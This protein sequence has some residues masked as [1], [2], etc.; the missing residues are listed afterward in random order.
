[1]TAHLSQ[2][3]ARVFDAVFYAAAY[4]D[5][6]AA[7]IA[8][9]EHYFQ[10]GIHENRDPNPYFDA[11]WYARRNPAAAAVQGG[12]IVHYL[13]AG[14]AQNRHPHPRF[15][16]VWY[17][18]QHPEAAGNQLHYH[19]R[20]G[21]QRGWPTEPFDI[22][23]LVPAPS[24]DGRRRP[25]ILFVA[26]SLG[27]G[28]RR[29]L[30]AL[31][32]DLR[33]RANCLILEGTMRGVA[34]SVPAMPDYPAVELADDRLPELAPLLADFG[35]SRVHIHHAMEAG[36]A[37][38]RLIHAL[39]VPFDV[40]VHDYHAI[41]PQI[42][43][44][45]W[46]DAQYCGEPGPA[47]CNACIA[48]RPSLE[49][50]DILTWRAAHRWM[51]LEADRVFCPS[52]DV[53][54]RLARH[55][56]ARRAILV[57]HEAVASGP[58]PMS[59]PKLSPRGRLRVAVLGVLAAHKGLPA[60]L[61]VLDADGPIDLQLIGHTEAPLSVAYDGR[62]HVTGFYAEADLP[63]L[64]R[65][66]KPHVVWFPAQWPET[67]S[68]TLSAAI[69]AG[70]PIVASRIG[71]FPERLAGRPLTWLIDP[72]APAGGWLAAFAEVRAT[73]L[74]PLPLPATEN[75]LEVENFYP[76]GYL[77]PLAS[78]PPA[79]RGS[80]PVDLRR[81]GRLSVIVVPECFGNG[82]ATPCAFIRLLQPLDHPAIGAEIDVILADPAEALGL[83]A[84]IVATQR[85]ALADTASADALAAHCRAHG[86]ALLY[87][88]DDDLLHIPLD[89]PEAALLRPRASTVARMLHHA[90]AV[91]VS[92][93]GLKIAIAAVRRD[94][95]VVANG[96]DERLWFDPPPPQPGPVRIL[97]MGSATHD[98][99]FD[100]V[101]PALAQLQETFND[102]LRIDLLGFSGRTDLPR[103]IHRSLPPADAKSAYPG[104]VNWMARQRFDIGIAPLADTRFN[105][106]KSAIKTM[107]YAALGLAVL[108]SDVPAYRGSL[109]DGPDG[110]LVANTPEAWFA[111]IQ[112]LIRDPALRQRQAD[113]ARAEWLRA[114][115]LQAQADNRR[116]AWIALRKGVLSPSRRG[117]DRR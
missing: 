66:L 64:L 44:L 43:L 62:I 102:G 86:M 83:R 69:E 2:A 116:A 51:F 117:R 24:F 25:T 27:G 11:A 33:G 85:Y 14:A 16:A 37:L 100:L 89:H 79:S 98:E 88:L 45:P 9:L 76:H 57:P 31:I 96:L 115:T 114:H 113:S 6:A 19:L 104:F 23:Q 47:G 54:R 10:F 72:G 30:D 93:P 110:G 99:D 106:S 15:D 42:V 55:G 73:L 105:A 65:R 67:Y 68:F 8:P 17:A 5:V 97:C 81:P 12:A 36:T 111:A 34:L 58:W 103:W 3:I 38:R 13:T 71:A 20:I 108:A 60:V 39:N 78:D 82:V 87:D 22:L 109:A 107:D 28:L 112:R 56:L 95:I 49:A 84:D 4:P 7:G 61:A 74:S 48:A 50:T 40:T 59:R 26:H 29:H 41:C 63:H 32:R 18:R 94:A 53:R 35:V 1:M 77:A 80:G 52:A 46:V 21:A 70:L 101:L 91:W 75:R 92:T 90:D